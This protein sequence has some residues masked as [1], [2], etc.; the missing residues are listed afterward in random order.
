MLYKHDLYK[1]EYPFAANG[2]SIMAHNVI[3]E[4]T[5]F[6]KTVQQIIED[7]E[8]H[9]ALIKAVKKFYKKL[10]AHKRGFMMY[11]EYPEESFI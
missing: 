2:M 3:E 7:E 5:I 1:I 6:I 8:Q 11:E 9:A 4:S 10:N